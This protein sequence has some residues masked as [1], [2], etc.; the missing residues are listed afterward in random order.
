MASDT[1]AVV[2][3]SVSTL[4]ASAL[5]TA[6]VRK[7]AVSSGLLDVP[8]ARSS[9]V[10]ATPRG[11]GLAIVLSA[12]ATL[13]IL[14]A[15]GDTNSA[16]CWILVGGGV[17]VAA[18][19]FA[20]DRRTISAVIRLL[21][22]IAAAAWVV[23]W[24]GGVSEIAFEG[25]I[26][27]LGWIGDVL[28]IAGVVWVLN[29]FNFM[30]GIDGIAASEAAFVTLAALLPL[31]LCGVS[32]AVLGA[33]LVIGAACLGFLPSNWSPAKIFLGDVGSG[34]I[35]YALA[36]LALASAHERPTTIWVWLILGGVFF[37]DATVTLIR[38]LVRGERIHEAHRSHAYQWLARR[39]RSHRRVTLAVLVINVFW[40]LPSA[41]F[42][43]LHPSHAATVALVALM[44]LVVIALVAGS[45]RRESSNRAQIAA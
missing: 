29:L 38:R 32:S 18:I 42:A 41:A 26:V 40:L 6:I 4:I 9:H 33:S 35:G 36:A 23:V 8:N 7:V 37:V 24:I 3:A 12:T 45:G 5:L 11:G 43:A 21:V 30:D 16:L 22:H 39:W 20:D 2:I 1:V 19:G 34:Y 10:K 17:A 13:L 25:H 44:P 27:H 15:A 31:S 14:T 28:G